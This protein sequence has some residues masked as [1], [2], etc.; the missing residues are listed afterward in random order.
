MIKQ[1]RIT[2]FLTVL[3]SPAIS[4]ACKDVKF[5]EAYTITDFKK[6]ENIVI[7]RISKSTHLKKYRYRPLLS[8]QATVL[9]SIKGVLIKGVSFSGKPK[10][11]QPRA[12]CPVHLTENGTYLLLLS[13]ENGKYVISRFSFPVKN[14]NKY[15]L[16]YISQIKN[17]VANE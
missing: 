14:D 9:E 15:Y 3:L 8:F 4:F 2:I 1:F 12:V 6:Y 7:A 11:E 10:E 13:K 16:N 5:G 17:A